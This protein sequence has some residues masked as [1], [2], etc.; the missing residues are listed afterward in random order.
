MR[1]IT[2]TAMVLGLAGLLA[3]VRASGGEGAKPKSLSPK[4]EMGV[5]PILVVPEVGG[6]TILGMMLSGTERKVIRV[7]LPPGTEGKAF[8]VIVPSGGATTRMTIPAPP[9]NDAYVA[10]RVQDLLLRVDPS[11]IWINP[12][13]E[14]LPEPWVRDLLLRQIIGPRVEDSRIIIRVPGGAK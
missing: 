12:W 13:K 11:R 10:P 7:T 14:A 4:I 5:T 6:E 9:R 2:G 1:G 8:R 3:A